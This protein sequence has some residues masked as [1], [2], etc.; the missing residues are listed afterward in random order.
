MGEHSIDPKSEIQN[1]R[2]GQMK[3]TNLDLSSTSTPSGPVE[4]LDLTFPNDDERRK[5]FLEKLA[6]KPTSRIERTVFL[7]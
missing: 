1:P 2:S 6:V 7:S 4:C 3:Q 5:Y